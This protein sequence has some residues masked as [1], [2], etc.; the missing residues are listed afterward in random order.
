MLRPQIM[1]G[2]IAL[3]HLLQQRHQL[4]LVMEGHVHGVSGNDPN[5]A[6]QRDQGENFITVAGEKSDCR[7]SRDRVRSRV[8]IG[9]RCGRHGKVLPQSRQDARR[10]SSNRNRLPST[11]NPQ[12]STFLRLCGILVPEQGQAVLDEERIALHDNRRMRMKQVQ[13]FAVGRRRG[14]GNHFHQTV[15]PIGLLPRL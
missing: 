13:F 14:V 11:L 3:I 5:Q 4:P 8:F 9:F 12:L 1:K 15:T 2:Q 7:R 6:G 10:Q